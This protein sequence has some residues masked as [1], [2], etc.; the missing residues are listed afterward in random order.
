MWCSC[1]VVLFANRTLPAI[2]NAGIFFVLAGVFITIIVCA[3]MPGR[4]GGNGYATNAFVWKDWSADIGYSSKGFIFLMGM[5]NGA[6]AVGVPDLVT[7]LAEELPRPE[8][9]VPK[10]IA[11]QTIVGFFTALCYMIAMFYA[12]SDLDAV[13]S[14]SAT[15]PLA[16]IYRQATGSAAGSIGLLAVILISLLCANS[17]LFLTTSRTLWTLARDGGTPFSH[18]LDQVNATCRNPFNAILTCGFLTALLGCLYVGSSTAFNAFVGSFVILSTLSY[19]ATILPHLLSRR[20]NVNPGP[21]W[22]KGSLG[23]IVNGIACSYIAVFVVIY[24]FPYSL[25]VTATTMNYS[26]VIT[27]GLT[28]FV[29]IWWT[30]IR[31]RGYKGPPTF[32]LRGVAVNVR[33]EDVGADKV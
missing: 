16:E 30:R 6:F 24:C 13:V 29:I 21:F 8:V 1:C 33:S 27:G 20:A 2:N 22:M 9:N 28:V 10:A 7:H 4:P 5:L 18:I 23:F 32:E 15:L 3:V 11:A 19:I 12:I 26:C 14:A 25:P 31:N 17:T